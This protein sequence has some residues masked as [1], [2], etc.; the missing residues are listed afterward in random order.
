M[1][2]HRYAFEDELNCCQDDFLLGAVR[3]EE[4]LRE[5]SGQGKTHTVIYPTVRTYRRPGRHMTVEITRSDSERNAEMLRGIGATV[6]QYTGRAEDFCDVE[7][8]GF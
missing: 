7:E 3:P 8:L 2:A 4:T 6:E 1:R 5:Q